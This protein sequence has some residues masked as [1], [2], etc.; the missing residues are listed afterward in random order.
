MIKS[1]T[2]RDEVPPDCPLHVIL[3]GDGVSD[4]P[5]ACPQL[6][7]IRGDGQNLI[8]IGEARLGLGM[9]DTNCSSHATETAA[10]PPNMLM[11]L[12]SCMSAQSQIRKPE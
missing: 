2:S 3:G 12:N 8:V 5:Q 11:K 6:T 9:T 10:A 4:E 7:D 1:P